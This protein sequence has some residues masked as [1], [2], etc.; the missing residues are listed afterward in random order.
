M[1][2]TKIVLVNPPQ[3]NSIDDHLDPPLGLLYIAA[4]LEK[5]GYSPRVVDLSG[6]PES[7]W[8]RLIGTADIMGITVYT[9]SLNV[10]RRIAAISKRNNHK[11][12]VVAGGPHPTSLPEQTLSYPEF[13]LV[14]KGEGEEE[15]VNIAKGHYPEKRI[16]QARTLEDLDAFPDPA[17]HL[18]D[19]R[20][21]HRN[22]EGNPATTLIT[23]RG[24]PYSCNFC[25]R[26]IHG[27]K[28]RFRSVERVL[29][30]IKGIQAAYGINSF[31]FYDD[32]FTMN[33]GGR[34]E[35]LCQGIK[36]LNIRFRCNGRV[37]V[38]KPEDY[39]LLK[40]AGCEEIAFG[41]ESGSQR[42]LNALNKGVTVGQNV[43]AIKDAKAAGLITKAYLVVGFP[44]ET[45]ETIDETKKFVE[46]ADPDKFTL[47]AFVPLPGCDVWR[48]PGKYGV[49]NISSDWDQ[50]FNI[51]GQYEGGVTF[52]TRDLS[53][54][55]FLRLHDDLARFLLVRGQRGKLE[56]YYSKLKI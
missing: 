19:I 49:T 3:Q 26:D 48:N 9:A 34:L 12:K 11:L 52:E 1:N 20:G 10:S 31:L 14:V 45:Q 36:P 50:Y 22:V 4:N 41:I 42:I 44:G 15:M 30:E 46:R 6:Q 32:V 23:S 5:N 21:Y 13:D 7:K 37:G 25:C 40:E 8:E 35:R 39:Q 33:I 28:V 17:R 24:C 54:A 51:A 53:K 27:R 38:N 43:Q 2:N 56:P 18:V 29:A 47:F 55:E 16:V